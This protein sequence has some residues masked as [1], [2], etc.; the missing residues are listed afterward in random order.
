MV[1]MS[2]K[3]VKDDTKMGRTVKPIDWEK[4]DHMLKAGC[5]GTQI[6]PFFN[7]H[8]NTF[9]DRVAERYGMT[10]TEYQT[11][12][13][14]EGDATLLTAQYDKATNGDNT[15]MVW[16]GKN[17][18]KQRENPTELTVSTETMQ[19][20][21]EVMNQVKEAQEALKSADTSSISE[22]KS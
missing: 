15:M 1:I 19:T 10:F 12:K 16:L 14:A 3:V 9:Y 11:I 8:P 6:C 18:L 21:K 7:M 2:V 17:R 5:D 22:E 20:F 13:R 4:V